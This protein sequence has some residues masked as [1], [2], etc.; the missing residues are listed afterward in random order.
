MSYALLEFARDLRKPA[1]R[2]RRFS[3][4]QALDKKLALYTQRSSNM[5]ALSEKLARYTEDVCQIVY[6]G[7]CPGPR[8]GQAPRPPGIIINY[9]QTRK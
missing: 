8:W 2:A 7:R 1:F 5:K 4:T 3:I 6:P 9:K